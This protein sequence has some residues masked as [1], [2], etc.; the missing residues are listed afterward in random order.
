MSGSEMERTLVRLAHQIVEKNAGPGL[1]ALIGIE[2]RG[3]P[4]ARRLAELISAIEK[5]PVETGSLNISAYRDDLERRVPR[6]TTVPGD[7][8]FSVE[9]R[10]ILLVD[11][12]LYTGRST[13]A[14]MDALFDI[15]R[16]RR[17]Q[18]VTLIDRGHRELPVEAAFVGRVI[19]TTAEQRI[20]VLVS[21]IDGSDEVLLHRA[22]AGD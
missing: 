2:T 21:E 3:V 10:D 6:P 7:V 11:D 18:L 13:R 17:I 22:G 20:E 9:G 8:P 4:L 1:P 15:G 14:A 12:V 19:D 5:Q 16:P